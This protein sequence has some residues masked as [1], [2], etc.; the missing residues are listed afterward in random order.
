MSTF[1]RY[2]MKMLGRR[3]RKGHWMAPG[4]FTLAFHRRAVR[5]TLTYLSRDVRANQI[6]VHMENEKSESPKTPCA[7]SLVV[8]HS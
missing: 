7:L 2:V 1:G 3:Y 8:N 6:A 4:N 5:E